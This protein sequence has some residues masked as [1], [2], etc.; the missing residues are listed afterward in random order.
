MATTKNKEGFTVR[1]RVDEKHDHLQITCATHG[2]SARARTTQQVVNALNFYNVNT[3]EPR[4]VAELI[5]EAFNEAYTTEARH[6]FL[7]SWTPLVGRYCYKHEDQL[8]GVRDYG[9]VEVRRI[10]PNELVDDITYLRKQLQ[11]ATGAL[12]R[13]QAFIRSDEEDE[14]N[15]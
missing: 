4:V 10:T 2:L 11:D 13:F 12:S 5:E 6:V 8:L 15:A 9:R 3:N 1:V 7:D 14:E